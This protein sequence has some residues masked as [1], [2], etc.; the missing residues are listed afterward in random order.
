[1]SFGFFVPA[2]PAIYRF[3]AVGDRQGVNKLWRGKMIR[4]RKDM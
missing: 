4:K 1:M 2:F 3:V